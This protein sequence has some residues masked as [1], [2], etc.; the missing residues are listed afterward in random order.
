MK[1]KKLI[2]AS[3]MMLCAIPTMAQLE[4][5]NR[6]DTE[7][8][9]TDEK[10][11]DEKF[12][13]GWDF[14]LPL[15]T[16]KT[17]SAKTDLVLGSGGLG[18]GFVD[19]LGCPEGMNVKMGQSLEFNWSDMI[20]LKLKMK[21]RNSIS[22]GMGM[23]WRNYRMTDQNRFVQDSDGTIGIEPYPV[24]ANPNFSRL[25]TTS[26]TFSLKYSHKWG[27]GWKVGVGPELAITPGGNKH[28]RSLKTRYEL[29][30]HKYKD[31]TYNVHVNPVTMNMV[32]SLSYKGIGLYARWSP[33]NVL[34]T[35]YGPNFTS[36]STGIVLFGF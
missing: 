19:A 25:H 24:G 33:S 7:E 1:A 12:P 2:L 4:I 15:R 27:H 10:F 6:K 20:A 14:S 17:S 18:I 23:L 11:V 22:L 35:N 34:D 32:A 26:M 29:D 21:N 28:N 16:K 31:K 30:D 9:L 13:G 5:V 36:L 8:N 3:L